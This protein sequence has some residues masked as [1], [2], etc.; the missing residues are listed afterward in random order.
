[1]VALA[2]KIQGNSVIVENDDINNYSG[3]Q[4]ILTILDDPETSKA[5]RAAKRRA[6]LK[7]KKA[8]IPSGRS[9]AEID[10]EIREARD[11]DRV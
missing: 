10:K 9:A 7:S 5:D 4:V 1:M 3:R 6:F 2:G 11:N 8:V